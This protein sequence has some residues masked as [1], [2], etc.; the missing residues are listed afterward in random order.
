MSFDISALHHLGARGRAQDMVVFMSFFQ[1]MPLPVPV[2]V[3]SS[4]PGQ[5]LA[6][7]PGPCSSGSLRLLA[8]GEASMIDLAG[9]GPAE[10]EQDSHDESLRAD[11]PAGL[12]RGETHWHVRV[13]C[14]FNLMKLPNEGTLTFLVPASNHIM[15]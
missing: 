9:G 6:V 7:R 5:G 13:H 3:A 4:G 12:R 1:T 8:G 14:N 11:S 10:S 15:F 2:L